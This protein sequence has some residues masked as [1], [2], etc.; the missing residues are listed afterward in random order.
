MNNFKYG[1]RRLKEVDLSIRGMEKFQALG[2][3]L[4]ALKEIEK[5]SKSGVHIG[6]RNNEHAQIPKDERAAPRKASL[7]L[8]Y[9][10]NSGAQPM[11]FCDVFLH[12]QALENIA[13]SM[14]LE[15]PSDDE[16]PLLLELFELCLT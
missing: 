2:S 7:V 10:S 1:V 4:V 14:I 8:F 3:W 6:D 12:S 15:V 13:I 16:V 5:D 9:D 11:N